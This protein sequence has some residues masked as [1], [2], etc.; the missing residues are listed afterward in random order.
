MTDEVPQV[1]TGGATS[2][3]F[4]PRPVTS[5]APPI[6]GAGNVYFGTG[7]R[8]HRRED[9][10]KVKGAGWRRLESHELA[11]LQTFP[12]DHPWRGTKTRVHQQIGDAVPPLLAERIL[13]MVATSGDTADDL[14]AGPGGWDVAATRLGIDVTGIEFDHAACETR[15]AAGLKTIEGDVRDFAPDGA[16]GLIAS[17]PC[18]TF[19]TAGSGAGREALDDVLLAVK[20]METER[21]HR[22]PSWVDEKTE[23]VLEPLRWILRAHDEGIA[24]RW[25]VLEQVPTVLP[26]WEAY[27]DVLRSIGYSVVTGVL[28]A[29]QYGVPQTR[30]RAV[31]IASLDKEVRLP[32]PTHSRYYS[33]D[34]KRLDDGVLPWVSMADALGWGY[35]KRPSGT[36]VSQSA[37]GPRL[38]DGG[39]GAAPDR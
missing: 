13:G 7:S 22:L 39:S 19:S 26:V 31:L 30:R 27:A 6:T 1:I 24:Y 8:F 38:L 28:N 25:I 20:T 36:L 10:L 12:V 11:A 17:P 14:F 5:P 2:E 23:L 34:P 35:T 32:E 18:Q 33:R 3:R 16:T 21:T 9:G 37:G 29:E 15:R 4:T